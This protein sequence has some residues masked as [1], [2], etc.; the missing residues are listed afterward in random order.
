MLKVFWWQWRLRLNP[1]LF[2][3]MAGLL[4]FQL[5]QAMS[6]AGATPSCR[7]K[8]FERMSRI[9]LLTADR[10]RRAIRS[11]ECDSHGERSQPEPAP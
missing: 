4:V 5:L 8:A 3:D 9:A 7:I 10:S 2:E 6:A 11:R 1:C